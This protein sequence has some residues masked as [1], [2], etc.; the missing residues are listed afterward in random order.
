MLRITKQTDYGLMLLARLADLPRDR[1][2]SAPEAADWSGLSVPMVSK[3]LK[4]LTR[5]EIVVSTRG[6]GGGYRLAAD[7]EAVSVADVIRALEGPISMVEC[8]TQ[9]GSCEH[10]PRCPVRVNWSRINRELERTLERIPISEMIADVPTSR[11][12]RLG[13]EME[14]A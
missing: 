3:I 14:Q 9:P 12:I 4:L 13:S 2:L 6:A 10:E 11:L 8:A 7:P 5:S 1:V